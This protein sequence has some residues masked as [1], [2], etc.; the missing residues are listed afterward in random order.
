MARFRFSVQIVS[1][2]RDVKISL[3]ASWQVCELERLP[4]RYCT[5]HN[6][7]WISNNRSGVTSI[8]TWHFL[9]STDTVVLPPRFPEWH[10]VYENNSKTQLAQRPPIGGIQDERISKAYLYPRFLKWQSSLFKCIHCVYN[11]FWKAIPFFNVS[12]WKKN[13]SGCLN[14]SHRRKQATSVGVWP[15]YGAVHVHFYTRPDNHYNIMDIHYGFISLVIV[16]TSSAAAIY[17]IPH[18]CHLVTC[19]DSYIW[20]NLCL[21]N[22][23]Y[24]NKMHF[25]KWRTNQ[26]LSSYINNNRL[27]NLT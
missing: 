3:L 24:M 17:V 21:G 10:T 27:F 25:I 1:S 4:Y 12:K 20:Q 8:S 26:M 11:C 14:V 15:S 5:M 22:C 13:V 23:K 7:C 19:S 18:A 16:Q 9:S 2:F 6:F